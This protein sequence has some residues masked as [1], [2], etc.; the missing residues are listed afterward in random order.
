LGGVLTFSTVKRLLELSYLWTGSQWC[1]VADLGMLA[2]LHSCLVDRDAL[3][4]KWEFTFIS[5]EM[6][7]RLYHFSVA[8]NKGKK[9][10]QGPFLYF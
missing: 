8:Y 10:L 5:L 9:L 6:L 3:P 7:C 4:M 2:I 1:A